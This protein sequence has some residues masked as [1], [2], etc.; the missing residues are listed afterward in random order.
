MKTLPRKISDI[1]PLVA[2]WLAYRIYQGHQL[3]SAGEAMDK[4]CRKRH[5]MAPVFPHVR[6]QGAFVWPPRVWRYPSL[7]PLLHNTGSSEDQCMV[8]LR[9]NVGGRVNIG[10]RGL[11]EV[12][13]DRD[14]LA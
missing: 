13:H 4:A 8:G 10:G 7:G 1:G 11:L 9:T 12:L 3:G 2:Y 14:N 6:P 5:H